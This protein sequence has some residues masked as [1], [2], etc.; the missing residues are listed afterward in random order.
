MFISSVSL[1]LPRFCDYATRH[2]IAF[3]VGQTLGASLLKSWFEIISWE[4]P[5]KQMKHTHTRQNTTYLTTA[6]KLSGSSWRGTDQTQ[7]ISWCVKSIVVLQW[8]MKNKSGAACLNT[9]E[10]VKEHRVLN[11]YENTVWSFELANNY[12]GKQWSFRV[13][14]LNLLV[15]RTTV[16]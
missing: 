5:T 4:L 14:V 10:S 9:Q 6:R 7:Q 2:R 1:R 11:I 12:P 13:N 16:L 15:P 3:C 8:I